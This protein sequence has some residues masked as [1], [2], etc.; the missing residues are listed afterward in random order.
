MAKKTTCPVT[1]KQFR[2]HAKPLPVKIGDSAFEAQVKQFKPGSFGWYLGG[3]LTVNIDGHEVTVQIGLNMAVVGSKD[4]PQDEPAAAAAP[5]PQ[6][7]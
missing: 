7:A 5:A 6:Q 4:L 3:K 2:E 1:R